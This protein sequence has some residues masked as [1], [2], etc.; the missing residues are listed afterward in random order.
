ME[1][2][3]YHAENAGRLIGGIKFSG[4]SIFAGALF[5]IYETNDPGQISKLDALTS[6]PSSGV[7]SISNH[8]YETCVKKNLNLPASQPF[9]TLSQP[10]P[11]SA[12]IKGTGVAVIV[13]E[14]GPPVED[15]S[16]IVNSGEP[17]ESVDAAIKIEE[18]KGRSV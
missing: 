9:H 13:S 1:T 2:K 14:P 7:T 4:Y 8:E 16:E 12:P 5:G 11:P 15:K 17:L 6:S 10:S 18:V 3:Y